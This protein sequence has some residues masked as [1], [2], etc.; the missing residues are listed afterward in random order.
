[1]FTN[2]RAQAELKVSFG[3]G[4][5]SR[6]TAKDVLARGSFKSFESKKLSKIAISRC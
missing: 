5:K 6:V 1:M 2:V 3:N 4:R